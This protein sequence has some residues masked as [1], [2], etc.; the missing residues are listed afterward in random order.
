MNR[1]NAIVEMVRLDKNIH[2][3]P[4]GICFDTDGKLFISNEYK[5]DV[6]N[7]LFK[8]LIINNLNNSFFTL[9]EFNYLNYF[10][11]YI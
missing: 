10:L 1:E 8:S 2:R 6:S 11:F 4:K 3:Q 7:E 9:M 5:G